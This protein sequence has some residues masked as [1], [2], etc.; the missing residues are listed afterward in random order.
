MNAEGVLLK[1]TKGALQ[2][3]GTNDCGDNQLFENINVLTIRY[4]N[5]SHVVYVAKHRIPFSHHNS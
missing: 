4:T 5:S 2:S 1:N 3:I